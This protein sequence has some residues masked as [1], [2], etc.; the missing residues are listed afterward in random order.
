MSGSAERPEERLARRRLEPHVGPL[1]PNDVPGTTGLADYRIAGPGDPGHVEVTSRPDKTRKK[2]QAALRRRPRFSVPSPGEWT[3][4]LHRKVD[5]R[6][7]SEDP[8]L[9]QVLQAAK[10]AGRLITIGNCPR[11]IA[12]T[13]SSSG[14]EAA[15]FRASVDPVGTVW[16]STG[17]TGARGVQGAGVDAWLRTAFQEIG[18]V[19]HVKK[20]TRAGGNARHLYL[21]VDSSSEKGLAIAIGL[22][23]SSWPGAAPYT[24]PVSG[25]PAD[26]TD[27]WIW[28]DSPGPGLHFT[29]GGGWAIVEDVAW[30]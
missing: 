24:L 3:L 4:Y 25:P 7:L 21:E 1:E 16:L 17:T 15:T 27:L 23:A 18:I 28:P 10:E 29:R 22:D 6:A 9:P 13:M 14:I 20:L 5:T 19:N 12:E 30:E 26:V 11:E 2:Q 8:R